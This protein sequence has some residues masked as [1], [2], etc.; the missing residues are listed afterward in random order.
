MA[1]VAEYMTQE[2]MT[3]S[4]DDSVAEVTARISEDTTHNGFPVSA[5]GVVQGF[6]TGSDLLQADSSTK[7]GEVMSEDT[8]VAAPEM[9][10][11][12]A[13]R[14][15]V[16]SDIQKLPVV[17]SDGALVG[18][19]SNTDVIRSQIERATPEKVDKLSRTLTEIHG[20]DLSHDRKQVELAA[21]IPT[22]KQ[23]F[24]DELR[25]RRYEL[26]RDLA[27][28]LVVIDTRNTGVVNGEETEP[29]TGGLYLADGHH[30]VLAAD[31]L[32]LAQME[33]YVIIPDAPIDL[34]IARTAAE[35]G[36][37]SI[38][39][40]TVVDHTRHPLVETTTKLQ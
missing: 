24:A 31:R 19:I 20:V 21:L 12:D 35:Q 32:G 11:T 23:V 16:R 17:D 33:A 4:P 25:G 37:N 9:Q 2:V 3:V 7:V 14:V 5:D 40:V 38:S 30:R 6:V 34:G 39:D 18:I 1:T 36:L 15:M 22:Q 28:P 26:E 8:I 13:A 29:I 10:I 27:E